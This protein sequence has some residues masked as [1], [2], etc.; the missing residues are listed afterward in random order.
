MK[1]WSGRDKPNGWP[2]WPNLCALPFAI[3]F[4]NIMIAR[5]NKL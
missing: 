5:Q 1:R 3:L 2:I 4:P